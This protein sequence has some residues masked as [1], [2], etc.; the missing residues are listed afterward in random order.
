MWMFSTHWYCTGCDRTNKSITPWR[1][2]WLSLSP[3]SDKLLFFPSFLTNTFLPSGRSTIS[4]TNVSVGG[5]TPQCYPSLSKYPHTPTE[6]L[7]TEKCFSLCAG[8]LL[9]GQSINNGS[10]V[11]KYNEAGE[12]KQRGQTEALFSSQENKVSAKPCSAA[13]P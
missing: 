10:E 7:N 5:D 2:Y 11:A 13:G 4:L 12:R 6:K 1:C 3:A 9:T 8:I